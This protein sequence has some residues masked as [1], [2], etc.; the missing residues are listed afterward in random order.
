MLV[1]ALVFFIVLGLLCI[2]SFAQAISDAIGTGNIPM[3]PM[4]R[5]V[6][7]NPIYWITLVLFSDPKDDPLDYIRGTDGNFYQPKSFSEKVH[8]AIV[9]H[10]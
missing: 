8:L 2:I 10:P 5:F 6:R 3:F 1:A 7:L 4:A 9:G